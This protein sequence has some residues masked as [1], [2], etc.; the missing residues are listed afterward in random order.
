MFIAHFGVAM[1]ARRVAP[2]PAFGTLLLAAMLV[3]GIWPVFVLLNWERVEIVPGITSAISRSRARKSPVSQT[4]P[5]I[6]ARICGL[7]L[8][9]NGRTS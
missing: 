4:G 1:A 6:S 7:P 3:D 8:N 5:T 2:Q 9:R